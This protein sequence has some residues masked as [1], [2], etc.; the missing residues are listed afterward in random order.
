MKHILYIK[1]GYSGT[2]RK[3]VVEGYRKLTSLGGFCS[4]NTNVPYE[5]RHR[6]KGLH[7]S[8]YD[9][10]YHIEREYE[11]NMRMDTDAR[12]LETHGIKSDVTI[13][14]ELIDLYDFYDEIGYVRKTKKFN[15]L[16][17]KQHILTNL[18]K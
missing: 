17:L 8:A 14:H 6:L 5:L 4:L 12:L 13:N 16:S 18:G 10:V 11:V 3:V 7:G 9:Y 1:Y 15:G 2:Y